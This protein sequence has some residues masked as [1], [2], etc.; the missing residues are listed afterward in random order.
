MIEDIS[1]RLKTEA[2]LSDSRRQAELYVDLM[3]HDI[4]NLNQ[5][6]IGYLELAMEAPEVREDTK[7]MMS[8]SLNALKNSSKLVDNVRKLQRVKTGRNKLEPIDVDAV[9]DETIKDYAHVPYREVMFSYRPVSDCFVYADDLLKDVFVNLIGNAIKHSAGPL[10][11]NVDVEEVEEDGKPYYRIYVEDNGPGIPDV[12]KHNLFDRFDS[13]S[14][15]TRGSG[16][17]LYLVRT[18]VKSYG[19]TISIEDRVPGD[20]RNGV[21]FVI[22]LPK[23]RMPPEE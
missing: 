23:L 11:I 1:E 12:R 4:N 2:V 16:L 9:I 3:G 14:S 13:E 17:G 21:R 6:G 22:M 7:K 5:A 8:G 19:G 15:R 20:Y 18:L 10:A